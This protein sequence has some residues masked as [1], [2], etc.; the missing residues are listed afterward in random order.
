MKKT[1]RKQDNEQMLIQLWLERPPENRTWEA[2]IVQFYTFIDSNHRYL[3][4]GMRVD[5]LGRLRTILRLYMH[6]Q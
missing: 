6:E 1:T 3:F 5:P 2:D 4:D